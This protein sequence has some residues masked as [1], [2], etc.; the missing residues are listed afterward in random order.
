MGSTP[1]SVFF[2]LDARRRRTVNCHSRLSLWISQTTDASQLSS[3]RPGLGARTGEPEGLVMRNHGLRRVTR[4]ISQGNPE[5]RSAGPMECDSSATGRTMGM[6]PD[7][8]AGLIRKKTVYPFPPNSG[9]TG[10]LYSGSRPGRARTGD[11]GPR[12]GPFPS[13]VLSPAVRQRQCAG[14]PARLA[15]RRALDRRRCRRRAP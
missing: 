2:A 11:L 9:G 8:P 4:S 13:V 7:G 6:C 12:P 3:M 14:P 5:T 15:R 10:T 1:V